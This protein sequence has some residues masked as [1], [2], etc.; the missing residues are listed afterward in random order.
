M[1]HMDWLGKLKENTHENFSKQMKYVIYRLQK[2]ICRMRRGRP[3]QMNRSIIK[4]IEN[5]KL[6]DYLKSLYAKQIEVDSVSTPV[7]N[8][9][10]NI[11][12][13]DIEEARKKKQKR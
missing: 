5:Q 9:D 2:E 7:R 13:T 8:D 10:L 1:K 4:Y 6:I 3:G 11:E 12:E